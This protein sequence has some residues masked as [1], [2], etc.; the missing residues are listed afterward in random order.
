MNIGFDGK[1]VVHNQTSRGN[2]NRNMIS[3]LA[4]AYPQNKYIIYSDIIEET[5]RLTSL[6]AHSSVMLKEPRHGLNN[7]W[8]RCGHGWSKDM[9]RHHIDVYHGLC[10]V[11]PIKKHGSR[12]RLVLSV[13]DLCVIYEGNK[14]GWWARFK[15]NRILRRS[16]KVADCIV[17]PS[18]WAKNE[19]MSRLGVDESRID[20][21]PPCVD[22]AFSKQALD[23]AKHALSTQLGLPEKFLLVMGP[24]DGYKH[25]LEMVR[26]LNQLKD[27]D[28]CLVLVE[29]TSKYYRKVVQPYV[30]S[31][32]LSDRV[33]HLK[34]LH[35]VDLPIVYQL[36]SAVLCP[37]KH[38][39]YSLSM[40]EA[41][42]C[43][44]PVVV[45]ANTM[46]ASEAGTAV[47][48]SV[49]DSPA[50]WASAI[51]ELMENESL[52]QLLVEQG[53]EFAAQFTPEHTAQALKACYDRLRE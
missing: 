28:M 44:V 33:F 1:W 49:D 29:K 23:E 51:D 47:H 35:T 19:L 6:L 24:L 43:G 32:L 18:V 26:A 39:L 17:V 52:R 38:E 34:H 8:W 42:S 20:I 3:A 30:E 25:V 53:R 22:T 46:M 7:D 27:K 4:H 15:K 16:I 11:L 10:G 41:M 13:S 2:L 21:I 40:L 50:S 37:A 14:M 5:R 45:N 36:A 48:T 12:T 9:K 31:H